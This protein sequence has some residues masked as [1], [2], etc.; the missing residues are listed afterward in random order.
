[1]VSLQP[2]ISFYL[3]YVICVLKLCINTF[4]KVQNWH[5]Q[6]FGNCQYDTNKESFHGNASP[7]STYFYVSAAASC[8]FPLFRLE[9]PPSLLCFLPRGVGP[10]RVCLPFTAISTLA[11]RERERERERDRPTVG[12]TTRTQRRRKRARSKEGDGRGCTVGSCTWFT[13]IFSKLLL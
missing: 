13:N 12:T 8:S 7:T 6:L 2:I 5:S 1:M 11:E 3:M 10:C 9:V 4:A